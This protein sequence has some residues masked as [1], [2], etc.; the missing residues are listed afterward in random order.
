MRRWPDRSDRYRAAIQTDM[1]APSPPH[2]L[3]EE[4]CAMRPISRS[5]LASPF[6]RG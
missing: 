6:W 4:I 5:A 1:S 2:F 3:A